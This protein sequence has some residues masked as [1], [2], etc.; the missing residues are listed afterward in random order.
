MDDDNQ[1]A[2]KA[3]VGSSDESHPEPDVEPSEVAQ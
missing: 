1:Q 3:Q 2:L